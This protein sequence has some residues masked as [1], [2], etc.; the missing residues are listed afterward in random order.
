MALLYL[1]CACQRSGIG[2][3]IAILPGNTPTFILSPSVG[4]GLRDAFDPQHESGT[5]VRG[6][7]P[8]PPGWKP[9]ILT[10]RPHGT[11]LIQKHFSSSRPNRIFTFKSNAKAPLIDASLDQLEARAFQPAIPVSLW[12]KKTD[13]ALP[14]FE[15]GISCLLDRRFNR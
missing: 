2:L 9:E 4:L 3:S 6:I 10:T 11:C 14:G 15:P 5:P 8:R 13:E 1:L 7:E 12:D